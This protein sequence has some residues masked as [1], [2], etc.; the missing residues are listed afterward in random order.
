MSEFKYACPVCGQHMMCDSSQSGTVMECPTCFQ[1]ITAP[2]APASDDQKFILTGTKVGERPPPKTTTVNP[3]FVPATKNPLPA[4]LLLAVFAGAV[5]A[6]IFIFRGKIFSSTGGSP[7][8]AAS[9][10]EP[11][12]T[13]A[14]HVVAPPSSDANWT[15]NLASA[16]NFPDAPVAGRIHALDFIVERAYFQNG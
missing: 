11:S 14:R 6:G 8:N 9:A 16:T 13:Q 15:L 2:Q 1:K 5:A 7:T 10:S 12:Q 3:G 4:I